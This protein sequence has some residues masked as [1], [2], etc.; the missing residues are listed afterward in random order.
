M[1][2]MTE[3][4]KSLPDKE[5]VKDIT[6]EKA[7]CYIRNN[8]GCY[9]TS[10]CGY[11]KM[12]EELNIE[13]IPV[14]ES[15]QEKH[16]VHENVRNDIV[17]AFASEEDLIL[18]DHFYRKRDDEIKELQVEVVILRNDLSDWKKGN[19]LLLETIERLKEENK[20]LKGRDG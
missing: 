9:C 16:T 6:I 14:K 13:S 18:Y 1:I 4:T 11:N 8:I 10:V 17:A 20:N 15:E 7:D 12:T 2:T 19:N 3:E 5:P